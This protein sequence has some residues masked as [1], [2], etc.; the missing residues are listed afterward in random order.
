M[1]GSEVTTTPVSRDA[2]SSARCTKLYGSTL[3][4]STRQSKESWPRRGLLSWAVSW[5]IT[6]PFELRARLAYDGKLLGAVP[7]G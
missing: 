2:R 5:S 4:I 6:F 7:L 3:K 1:L